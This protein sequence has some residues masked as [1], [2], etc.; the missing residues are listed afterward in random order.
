[1]N[2]RAIRTTFAGSLGY[3]LAAR[4]D[5]PPGR[6]R[7]HA[8]FAHCFTCTKDI[9]AARHIAAKLASL[10][11]AVLRFDFT[12]LGSSEGEFQNT[13]FSSNVEDLIHAAN[14]LRKHYRAPAILIGHSLG[15]AAVLAA[16]H[17]IP[18]ARAVVT[19][20]APSDVAHVLHHFHAHLDDIERDGVANVTLAGRSFPIS[21]GLVEDARGQAIENHVAN[22]RK[23]LLV[24]HAPRD[25]TVGIEHATAIFTT[26]KHPKSFI[27]LDS[28]DHLL[29]DSRDAAYAA[30]VLGAWASRYVPQHEEGVGED[31]HDGV[32]VAETG[33][34][35]F[36]NE[37]V[38]GR[39]RLLADEPTSAGGLDSG[40]SPY[41][42]LAAA[43]GACTS[44][45][46][47]VYAEHKRLA[48][49]RLVVSVRH[50]KLPAEHCEDCGEAAEGRTGN[51]DRFERVISVEGGVDAVMADKLIEIAGKCPVHRTLEA[52]SAVV[53]RVSDNAPPV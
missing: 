1:M 8:L 47:R 10:G 27:S 3:E 25:Q 18:E 9:V 34:G 49:G 51:I 40:P 20:G 48:L 14:H 24:M 22:L 43:L 45:T 13:N 53:T 32:V 21:R 30:E 16:A 29:S 19:I 5:L 38:A 41:D 23:A 52:R 7:A 36:Q 17:R 26:A 39:H 6:V 33:A 50:G 44:M 15:G 11:I 2:T 28:A 31:R 37:I 42:Y 12:G 35:K 46:L 4:L